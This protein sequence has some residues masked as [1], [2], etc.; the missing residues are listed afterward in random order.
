MAKDPAFLF[1]SQDFIVG[2]Q[3]M[4]FEDRGKYITLLA[5]MHQQGRMEEKTIRFLV[6]SVSD[7]LKSKF[8]IDENGKWFNERLEEEAEKRNKFTE[9]R[10]NNGSKGGRPKKEIKPKGKPKKNLMEDVNENEDEIVIEIAYP[11][12]SE[13]F[14]LYWKMWKQY[15]RKE[16]KFNYKSEISEQAALKMLAKLANGIESKCYEIIENSIANGYKGFFKPEQNKKGALIPDSY[17]QQILD[18]IN[19]A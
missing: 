19:N 5:Q 14:L 6:G 3:T 10:R 7:N 15:K 11:F 9:S 17:K 16:H 4:D 12:E 8:A 1:Y 13:K 2:V 18:D